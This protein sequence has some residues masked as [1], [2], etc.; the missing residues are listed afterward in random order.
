VQAQIVTRV[1]SVALKKL[2]EHAVVNPTSTFQSRSLL[3]QVR[4]II[5]IDNIVYYAARPQPT[6][7]F[8]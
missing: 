1:L 3:N 6:A 8:I 7:L 5:D 4:E 2:E